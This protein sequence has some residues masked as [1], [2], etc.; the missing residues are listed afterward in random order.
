MAH[1][2]EAGKSFHVATR[3][4]PSIGILEIEAVRVCYGI[5]EQYHYE[6]KLTRRK[7]V[8]KQCVCVRVCQPSPRRALSLLCFDIFK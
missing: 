8:S 5:A 2:A 4:L 7:R 3:L 6:T 1:Q